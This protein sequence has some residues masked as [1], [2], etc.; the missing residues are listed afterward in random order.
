[1]RPA[2][3]AALLS[4]PRLAADPP[5][6]PLPQAAAAIAPDPRLGILQRLGRNGDWLV[7]RGTHATDDFIAGVR[8]APFSHVAILDAGREEV[9]EAEGKGIHTTPLRTFL[10]KS[11]RLMLV[12]PQ[13]GD[14]DCQEEAL[15]RARDA[16]GRKYDFSGLVGLNHPE[17]YYCSELAVAIYRPCFTRKERIPKVV[18]P[19]QLHAWGTILYDSGPAGTR[20]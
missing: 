2:L 8:R 1:M 14:G 12:R 7:I 20:P 10:A 11:R 4:L 19:D 16:V 13:W 5:D 17:R 9:I 6:P 15:Q 18:A 3:L